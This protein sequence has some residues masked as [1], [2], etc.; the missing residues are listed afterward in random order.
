MSELERARAEKDEFFGNDPDSPLTDEQRRVFRGLSYFTGGVKEYR[1]VGRVRFPV[2]SM[3]VTLQVYRH[4]RWYFVPFIEAIAPAETYGAGCYLEPNDH[5]FGSLHLDFNQAYNLYCA[6]V[7]REILLPRAS[8]EKPRGSANRGRGEEIPRLRRTPMVMK[9]FVAAFATISIL[10]AV[11][12]EKYGTASPDGAKP[13]L[14]SVT[15]N[16][17]TLLSKA[18]FQVPSKEIDS[19]DFT[20]ET[21]TGG[22]TKLSS[23]K[24][25]IVFLNFWATWCGPCN[26]ELPAIAALYERLKS[27]G[28]V[29]LGVDLAEQKDTVSTFV[30]KKG[31]PFPVLLDADGTVGSQYDASSI[32]T[33]YIID[34]NGRILGR[35]IGLD[36]MAWD[37]PESVSLF[38]KL[39]AM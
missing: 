22:T 13:V 30:K 10:S 37:S 35:K 32:P 31:L 12:A 26:I 9:L 39:L 11:A 38:E 3:E 20:L 24:G 5:E 17:A 14:V 34:R 28:L 36:S 2:G 29:V 7:Q 6:C 1:H 33:T 27:K 21:L 8:P 15:S 19:T 25:Q 4:E 18:G 16:A 23:L